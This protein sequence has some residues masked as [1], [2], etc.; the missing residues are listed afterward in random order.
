VEVEAAV[1]KMLLDK[2]AV[3]TYV[4]EWVFKH[5]LDEVVSGT[6][7][8][9]IVVRTGPGWATPD[10]VTTQEYPTLLL[11]FYADA[12]RD[13]SGEIL[14]ADAVD[15]A[16]ALYRVCDPL[17]HAK[18][19]VRWGGTGGLYVVTSARNGEPLTV[20]GRD[21]HGKDTLGDAAMVTVPYALQVIHSRGAPAA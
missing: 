16:K 8:A 9:A 17:L 18:R 2:D 19:G 13:H 6:G 11:E 10:R 3:R 14:R 20:L 5:Q 15:R 21:L 1:R 12:S 4:G 7:R